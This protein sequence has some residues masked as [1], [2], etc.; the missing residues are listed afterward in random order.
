MRKTTIKTSV[1]Y[2]C[3]EALLYIDE[4]NEL[5]QVNFEIPATAKTEKGVEKL[6]SDYIGEDAK[7][8]KVI[9]ADKK[10]VWYELDR[11]TFMQFA[12]VV[13]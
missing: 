8:V 4:V 3:V 2:T 11:E 5:R 12:K 9:S 1:T 6:V 10:Q 13:G 7:L